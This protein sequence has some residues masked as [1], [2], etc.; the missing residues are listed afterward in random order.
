MF[1]ALNVLGKL[2]ALS[3]KATRDCLKLQALALEATGNRVAADQLMA[4]LS[5]NRLEAIWRLMHA[6]RNE[7]PATE[8]LDSEMMRQ[9]GLKPARPAGNGKA[10]TGNGK[11]HGWDSV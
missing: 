6:A 9:V 3:G 2:N 10:H 11:A 7:N 4:K 1:D 8:S 5:A